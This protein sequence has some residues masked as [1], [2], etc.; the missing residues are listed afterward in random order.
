MYEIY[1]SRGNVSRIVPQNVTTETPSKYLDWIQNKSWSNFGQS[2]VFGQ[3]LKVSE[4]YPIVQ[5]TKCIHMI[6]K[7]LTL[8]MM[9]W[10]TKD[11]HQQFL[12]E[13][14]MR[15]FGEIFVER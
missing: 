1:L 8:R 11:L 15:V 12:Q 2:A 14:V 6:E 5:N 3:D 4:P 9:I 7:R 10:H 13:T